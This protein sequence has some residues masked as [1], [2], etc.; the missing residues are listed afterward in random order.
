MIKHVNPCPFTQHLTFEATPPFYLCSDNSG[1]F[2]GIWHPTGL[3]P[4]SALYAAA[5][6]ALAL[7]LEVI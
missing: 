5:S 4:P 7:V 3:A 6:A 2:S 1:S